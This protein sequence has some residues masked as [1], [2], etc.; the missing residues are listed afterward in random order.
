[1]I[2]WTLAI[3]GLLVVL[4]VLLSPLESLQ[5][6]V[7]RGEEEVRQTFELVPQEATVPTQAGHYVVYLS[8]VGTIGGDQLSRRESAWL[9]SLAEVLP[10]SRIVSD[11]FPYAVDNR[12]LLQ[13]ATVW[14]WSRLHRWKRKGQALFLPMLIELRNVAQVLVSA[15]P[16][17][18]PTYN[19]GLAQEIWRAL[20]RQGYVPGSGT[21][22]TLVGFSGGAQ[23][24]LGSG[25]FLAG[26][27]VPVS[28]ISVGGIFGDD[29]G[30]DR[31]QHMWHLRGARDRLHLIGNIA[32]PG[33]WPTAPFSPWARAKRDG[34]VTKLQIGPMQHAGA[35]GYMGR[36]AI[37]D[38]GRS[39]AEITRDAVAR[40]IR[41][42]NA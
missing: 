9:A 38:G 3:L 36:R 15:D 12:G 4:F 17:Y 33:R 22:V 5:W 30:L 28:M 8:G 6:W 26:L 42:S 23:V 27:G 14:L 1:M 10:G 2:A 24:A 41:E 40:I 29:P 32:F 34:R 39:H 18:G 35:G 20:Q 19:I 37:A 25:W 11:V 7:D 21:P 31:V 13:R 16:R